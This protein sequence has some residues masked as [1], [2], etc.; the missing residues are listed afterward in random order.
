MTER[1]SVESTV[2]ARG[3]LIAASVALAA[4]TVPV[5]AYGAP[6]KDPTTASHAEVLGSAPPQSS[7]V[8]PKVNVYPQ[9]TEDSELDPGADPVFA[10]D[11]A[12]KKNETYAYRVSKPGAQALPPGVVEL[13]YNVATAARTPLRALLAKVRAKLVRGTGIALYLTGGTALNNADLAAIQ[14]V[15]KPVGEGGLGLTNLNRLHIY[16]LRS[17]QGGRE[18]TPSSGLACAGQIAR[19]GLSPY[20]WYNG[21]WGSWVKHLVLDDLLKIKAGTFS[22]TNFE[23]VSF[24]AARSVGVMGFGHGPYAKLSVLY[25][26]SVT[27]IAHDAFR[28]NQYLVKVNLPHVK[29]IDDFAFDDASRLRYFNAPELVSLGRNALNDSHALVSVNLPKL[30]YLG[31]NCFDLNGDAAT[32]AGMKTL[33]LPSLTVAD[34]N[35]I[36]G[37]RSLKELYAPKLTTAWQYS[38]S[39]N[40][41]L[42]SVYVPKLKILGPGVFAGNPKLT[43]LKLPSVLRLPPDIFPGTPLQLLWLTRDKPGKSLAT[44]SLGLNTLRA[45]NLGTRPPA[46]DPDA[47]AG[48]DPSRLKIYYSGANPN[49]KKFVPAGNPT[50]KLVKQG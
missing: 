35:S 12:L 23:T 10:S 4:L 28:R 31:I 36:T 47:F 15:H 33:R 46:Q 48:A 32:G 14:S 11:A 27:R 43:R 34:K 42:Q 18:C 38:I 13:A 19:G 29:T 6:E 8:E 2:G 16:N 39:Y 37:F 21:W 22:N 50:I 49:W 24:K 25:L 3:R 5:A 44:R 26:P 7:P 9:N 1:A 17:L 20:L 45:V 30:R 41:N 40:A